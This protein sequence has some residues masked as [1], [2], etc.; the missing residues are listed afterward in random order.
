MNINM[1]H[2]EQRSQLPVRPTVHL[3]AP[4][5]AHGITH[6]SEAAYFQR[7]VLNVLQRHIVENI[8]YFLF[9]LK[10]EF[11]VIKYISIK[12]N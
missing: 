12:I 10:V 6:V 11:G 7:N 4:L 3:V 5:M 9:L 2:L 8:L 1:Q